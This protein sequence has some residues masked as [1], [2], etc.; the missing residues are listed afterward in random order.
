VNNRESYILDLVGEFIPWKLANTIN[1][2]LLKVYLHTTT[3]FGVF[4]GMS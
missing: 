4:K 1:Q 3:G 2:D